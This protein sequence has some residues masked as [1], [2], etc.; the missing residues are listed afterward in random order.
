SGARPPVRPGK[1]AAEKKLRESLRRVAA[2]PATPVLL[3][4]PSGAGKQCAAELLHE[5]TYERS[6][7]A[8]F[9]EVNCAA[10]PS[11]LVES[12]LFGHEKGAFT[13][14]RTARRGLVEMADSGTLFLDEVTELPERSQAKLLKFLD[15][16]R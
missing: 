2:S 9:V 13:D 14:A 7:D 11:D 15:T 10:L 16:M 1:S 4:G 5:M 3:E 8:P 12:E 6:E